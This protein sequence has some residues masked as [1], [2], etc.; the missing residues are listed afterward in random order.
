MWS[1][2]TWAEK[3]QVKAQEMNEIEEKLREF[4]SVNDYGA[5]GNNSADDTAAINAA[6]AVGRAYVPA[7]TY[8]TTATIV[9]PYGIYGAGAG[10]NGIAQSII[11]PAA[12]VT[13]LLLEGVGLSETTGLMFLSRSTESG[14]D[15][16]IRVRSHGAVLGAVTVEGFGRD[17]VNVDTTAGNAN[18]AT[19]RG[20]RA[21]KNYRHGYY[22][23][24]INSNAISLTS[25]E[26][27]NNKGWGFYID[28]STGQVVSTGC[29]AEFNTLGSFFD[30]GNGNAYYTPYVEPGEGSNVTLEG[31]GTT[32]INTGTFCEPVITG[33][34]SH[35]IF[36]KKAVQLPFPEA[37]IG[38]PAENLGALKKAVD[39]LRGVVKNHGMTL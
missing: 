2:R 1:Y 10:V 15:D 7:G 29:I 8:L 18:N 22:L 21:A 14:T 35:L 5:L 26:A 39:E 34:T 16:G 36:N 9:A 37:A 28:E 32:W 20:F 13:G 11:K 19:F 38:S 30:K 3:Q 4:V 27:Q 23:A 6:C 12:K 24:G 33:N 25:C 31:Y 17:G